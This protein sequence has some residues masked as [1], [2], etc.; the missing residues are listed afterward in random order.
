MK[1]RD[2]IKATGMILG[3]ALSIFAVCFVVLAWTGPGLEPPGGNA[4]SPLHVGT[5]GQI[6]DGPLGVEGVLRAYSNLIVDGN[7]G[8][9][10]A[11]PKAKFHIEGAIIIGTQETCDENTIGALRYS[12]IENRFEGCTG[13]D[14]YGIDLDIPKF[15]LGVDAGVGGT[16]V[17]IWN[18]SPYPEG[19]EVPIQA[20]PSTHYRFDGWS[21][22]AGTIANATD[23]ETTFTMPGEHVTLEASF[24]GGP[25]T[26]IGSLKSILDC[27]DIGGTVFDTGANG[28]ICRYPGS[29]VP[30]GWTQ[31]ANW[32]RYNPSSWGGDS[33][34]RWRTT[35]PSTFSNEQVTH[36]SR[37]SYYGG[38]HSTCGESWPQYWQHW[39]SGYF[40]SYHVSTSYSN[41][42]TNRVE[43]GLY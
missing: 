41:T 38:G 10:T 39:G 5:T 19:E 34:G 30:S 13:M 32:Q 17:D 21:A 43:I 25:L 12:S 29:T 2:K 16:A 7:V 15:Y 11:D 18:S 3:I 27:E 22:P 14:W 31:A 36:Y 23:A 35:G 40:Y 37:G 8:I 33:C 20:T 4:P 26:W 42:T 9:G 24:Y 28:T 6:K 1:T